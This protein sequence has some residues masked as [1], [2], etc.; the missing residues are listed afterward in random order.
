MHT[1]APTAWL[2]S[3]HDRAFVLLQAPEPL[4]GGD[5][6]IRVLTL[7]LVAVLVAFAVRAVGQAMA[8]VIE[9]ARTFMAASIATVLLLAAL[10]LV[11][12]VAFSHV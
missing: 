12:A 7:L 10:V 5:R 9:L 6:A 2:A 1:L 11:V 4:A 3:P 8:P